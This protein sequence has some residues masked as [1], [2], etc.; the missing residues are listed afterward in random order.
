MIK[1]LQIP[2]FDLTSSL[3]TTMD[4][5]H[6]ATANHHKQVAYIAFW[7]ANEFELSMSARKDIL[8][9]GALHDIG[10]MSVLERIDLLDFEVVDTHIHCETGYRLLNLFEPFDKIANIVRFHHVYWQNGQGKEQDGHAVPFESHILHIADRIAIIIDFNK[11]IFSQIPAIVSYIESKQGTMFHPK[12]VECFKKLSEKEFFWLD[13][14]SNLTSTRLHRLITSD[15]LTLTSTEILDLTSLFAKVIDFRSPFTATH[16]AGVAASAEAISRF[17]HFSKKELFMMRIA[18]NLH[19][20]GKVAIPVSILEKDGALTPKEWNV[21]RKH[22]Y[23]GYHILQPISDLQIINS[24]ASFHHERI[25]G[26]GYPFHLKGE[27]LS[28]G[29]RVMAVAD[30]FTAISEDRPYRKGM[31]DKQI[32]K[33]IENLVSSGGLDPEIVLVLKENYYEIKASRVQAEEECLSRYKG[34]LT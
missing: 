23:Y 27:E 13:L 18:G 32:V 5:I 28:L 4:L 24:W 9:A 8:L 34:L 12:L 15:T 25:D 26:S 16:S 31:T 10:A 14:A 11:E 30:V 20:L 7:I 33:V 1:E 19:D 29:S 21:M 17:L 2:V 6:P 3:S 22:T